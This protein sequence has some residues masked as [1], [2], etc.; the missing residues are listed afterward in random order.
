MASHRTE[1]QLDPIELDLSRLTWD[2]IVKEIEKVSSKFKQ[3]QAKLMHLRMEHK[4]ELLSP[5][6]EFGVAL[7]EWKDL[8]ERAMLKIGQEETEEGFDSNVNKK[9]SEYLLHQLDQIHELEAA[10]NLLAPTTDI[11]NGSPLPESAGLFSFRL[12]KLCL[13]EGRKCG[14]EREMVELKKA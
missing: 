11:N 9:Q 6:L 8:I 13:G 1:F 4:D 2:Q 10:P 5:K 7:E 3:V 12:F 14:S